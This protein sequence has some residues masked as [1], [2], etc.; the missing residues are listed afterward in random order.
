VRCAYLLESGPTRSVQGM[1]PPK[2][3]VQ[4]RVVDHRACGKSSAPPP[5]RRA[6]Q[7]YLPMDSE[8]APENLPQFDDNGR[9]AASG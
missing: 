5:S 1:N 4:L 8:T 3:Y 2:P 7:T 9:L 6:V